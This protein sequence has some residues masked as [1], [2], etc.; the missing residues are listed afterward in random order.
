VDK[1]SL[2]FPLLVADIIDDCIL[3]VDFLRKINLL[4]IFE[5]EFRVG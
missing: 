1:F 2:E 4:G 5:F 3:G